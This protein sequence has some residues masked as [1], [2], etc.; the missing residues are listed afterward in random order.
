MARDKITNHREAVNIVTC[1]V[2][3]SLLVLG[4]KWKLLLLYL[5]AFESKGG[6]LRYSDFV[7]LIPNISAKVLSSELKELEADGLIIRTMYHDIPPRVEYTLSETGA[8]LA[9]P[10]VRAIHT[11]GEQYKDAMRNPPLN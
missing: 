9:T 1:P 2:M 7:D 5:L 8:E 11:V 10:V 3:R 4:G 6:H